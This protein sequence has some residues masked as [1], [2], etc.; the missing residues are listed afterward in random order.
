VAGQTQVAHH[1]LLLHSISASIAPPFAKTALHRSWCRCRATAT[2]H[3]VGLQQLQRLLNHAHGVVA[4]PFFGLGG[5][6][7]LVAGAPSPA[8]ILLAPAFGATVDR[9]GVNVFTPR[10]SARSMMGT[11][12]SKL[13]AC[14]SAAWPPSEKIPTLY[15]VLPRLRVGI[16]VGVTG[17]EGRAGIVFAVSAVSADAPGERLSPPRGLEEFA[18]SVPAA[19][20]L[21]SP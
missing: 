9:R 5:Q 8:D 2:V 19:D 1:L 15:P 16:A 21:V 10:S 12:A 11:A 4:G 6:E 13:F 18:A 20:E 17:F 3:M 7:R 14:S